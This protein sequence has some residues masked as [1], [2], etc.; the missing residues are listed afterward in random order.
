M[1]EWLTYVFSFVCGRYA[2]HTWILGG[3]ELPCCQ[4]CT[5]LYA[6]AALAMLLHLVCRPGVTF[7]YR[8][9]H[10]LCLLQMA[11]MGLHL[12][13]QDAWLRCLSGQLF[14]YSLVAFMSLELRSRGVP[15]SSP[16]P[17]GN[18]YYWVGAALSLPLIP[19][20]VQWDGVFAATLLSV[21]VLAGGC[22]LLVLALIQLGHGAVAL[23]RRLWVG[24]VRCT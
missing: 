20:L 2:P 9:I 24:T 4:R 1:S 11:P 13:P 22:S 3:I 15:A 6:G 7:R 23:G 17:S 5:G 19:L 16:G 21:L 8:L 18:N 10:G 14:A 12:V